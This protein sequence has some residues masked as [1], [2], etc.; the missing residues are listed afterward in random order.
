M[1]YINASGINNISNKPEPEIVEI[2]KCIKYLKHIKENHEYN[3]TTSSYGLKIII[4]NIE[5]Y[6]SNGAFIKALNIL[7]MNYQKCSKDSPNV[8]V[9]FNSIDLIKT[10]LDIKLNQINIK[11]C[12]IDQL[13]I[14]IMDKSRTNSIKYTVKE[15]ESTINDFT[16]KDKISTEYVYKL[17]NEIKLAKFK[18]YPV[19][20]VDFKYIEVNISLL[21]LRR[22]LKIY[23][24]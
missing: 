10:I 4:E 22:L 15:I 1:E 13:L 16:G 18:F 20:N 19:T 3:N 9:K 7:K 5:G 2:D 14:H 17:I 8:W 21:K 11:N 23:F 12:H 24:K 6:V